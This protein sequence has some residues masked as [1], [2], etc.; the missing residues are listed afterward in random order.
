MAI[1]ARRH[2]V[3]GTCGPLRVRVD[4]GD[5][6][7][8]SF[9]QTH[10]DLFSRPWR[11]T[12][13][14]VEV[15]IVRGVD[16]ASVSG[17]YLECGN[18]RVDRDGKSFVAS[19]FYGM[20]GRGSIGEHTDTWKL[21]VPD[22]LVLNERQ[23]NNLE[24]LFSLICT[25]GWRTEGWIAVHA[26]AVIGPSSC[27]ILCATSGGGK[28]TLTAALLVAGWT[29][30][31]DDKLLLR[32]DG[33]SPEVRPLLN[34]LNLHPQTREWLPVPDIEQLPR[35]SAMTEK[36]RVGVLALTRL[37]LPD[38]A[39]PTHVICIERTRGH[40]EVRATPMPQGEILP[41]L[42]RQVVI[43]RDPAIARATLQVIASACARSITKGVRLQ[44][45]DGAYRN[46]AWIAPL[47]QA[48]S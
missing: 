33:P 26:G 1:A 29:T 19:T 38:A 27:A 13:R 7:L 46:A 14:D 28:S 25:T 9:A 23:I 8:E 22:D 41:T 6:E 44:I 32:T 37:P 35:Y 2:R 17:T 20:T 43:P 47:E 15:E 39:T 12:T 16:E 42:L 4:A 48:L 11:E 31:G 40:S 10:L 18:M 34:T 24:D 3:T 45:G 30:L 21:C 36:R 5:A